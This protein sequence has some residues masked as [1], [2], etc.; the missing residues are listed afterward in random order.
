VDDE[1]TA[2]Q[3]KQ[4]LGRIGQHLPRHN[5][6]KGVLIMEAPQ[7]GSGESWKNSQA[8]WSAGYDDPWPT[9]A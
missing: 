1:E 4:T 3:L 5:G 6:G 7:S 9:R 2:M 8:R